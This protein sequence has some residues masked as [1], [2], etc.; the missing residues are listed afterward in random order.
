M[1]S[2]TPTITAQVAAGSTSS[3]FFVDVVIR[4]KLCHDTC[5]DTTPVF[6]PTFAVVSTDNVGEDQYIITLSVE[7]VIHYTPCSRGVC[8]TKAQTV[9]ATF[10]IPYYGTAEPTSVTIEAGT[11]VNSLL[12]EPCHQCS[13]VFVSRTPITL[14]VA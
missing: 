12:T 13:D 3:P 1:K 9:S 5:I 8:Y 2:F 11:P 6:T 14:T 7:G 10:T 4:Q